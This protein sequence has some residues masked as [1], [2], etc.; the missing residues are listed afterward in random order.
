VIGVWKVRPSCG[1]QWLICKDIAAFGEMLEGGDAGDE[2]ELVYDEMT[3]E[4][5]TNLP[6]HGG[7]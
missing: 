2:Y 6:E 3:E 1:G 5:Y 4:D 7:W